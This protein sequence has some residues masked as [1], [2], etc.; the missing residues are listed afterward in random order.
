LIVWAETRDAC[1]KRLEGALR[2]LVIEGVPTT[3]PLHL[4]LSRDPSVAKTDFHTR[5]LEPWLK[6]DFAAALAKSEE[7]A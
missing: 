2:G 1:L 7:K 3:I 5:F 6:T 4:A